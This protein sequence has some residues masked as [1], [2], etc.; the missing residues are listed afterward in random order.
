MDVQVAVLYGFPSCQSQ[1]R[2]R[3][4]ALLQ[5]AIDRLRCNHLPF[6]IAGDLNHHPSQLDAFEALT[7]QGCVT[8]EDCHQQL[9]GHALPPTFTNTTRNDVAILSSELAPMVQSVQVNQD[10]LVAGHNPLLFDL[11]CPD[12][13]PTRTMWPLPHPWIEL[14][15]DPAEVRRSFTWNNRNFEEGRELLQWSQAV[16]QAVDAALKTKAH[17]SFPSQGLPDAYR[18]RCEN[19]MP[20]QTPLTSLIPPGRHDDFHP[21]IDQPTHLLKAWTSQVRRLKSLY[22]RSTCKTKPQSAHQLQTEW[23]TVLRAKGCRQHF[24]DWI[25]SMPE[26]YP[27]PLS[28]PSAS[29]LY[30]MCQLMEHHVNHLAYLHNKRRQALA[31]FLKERDVKRTA[32]KYAMLG[33]RR[34]AQPFLTCMVLTTALQDP[35][36]YTILQALLH[37]RDYAIHLPEQE[38]LQFFEQVS[39][40]HKLPQAIMGPAGALQ[41]YLAKLDWQMTSSGLIHV[42][43][44]FDLHLLQSNWHDIVEAVEISWLEHV[45]VQVSSRH[46]CSHMPVINRRSTVGVFESLPSP[47]KHAI[48]LQLTG[49]PMTGEQKSK[50][51]DGSDLCPYCLAPDSKEHQ[52]LYCEATQTIRDQHAETCDMLDQH[53]DI[54]VVQPAVFRHPD[55]DYIRTMQFS[56]PEADI[57]MRG[58]IGGIFTDGT[59]QRPASIATRWAAYAVVVPVSAQAD[60]VADAG[61]PLE[62]MLQKHFSVA[63]LALVPGAQNIPRAELLAALQAHESQLEDAEFPVY[64]DSSYVLKSLALVQQTRVV[65]RLHKHRNFDLLRRWRHLVWGRGRRTPTIKVK[66]HQPIP[67]S[68]PHETW[69]RIGNAV[70]DLVAKRAAF[71]LLPAYTATLRAMGEEEDIMTRFFRAQL[72][73]R[74]ELALFRKQLDQQS[75]NREQF[76]PEATLQRYQTW[77]VDDGYSPT[78]SDDDMWVLDLSR[79]GTCF[80]HVL[81]QWLSGLRFSK[82]QDPDDCG[83]TWFELLC[84]FWLQTQM[85]VPLKIDGYYQTFAEM[86]TWSREQFTINDAIVSFAGAIKHLEFLLQRDILP[87]VRGQQIPSL[88]RLG[89]GCHKLGLTQRPV[90]PLQ[91]ESMQWVWD[92]L[93]LQLPQGKVT[94]DFLPQIRERPARIFSAY[95]PPA[96]D[97]HA[98]RE[99]RFRSRGTK[100]QRIAKS[101]SALL[102]TV[103]VDS[104][105]PVRGAFLPMIP[106]RQRRAM[107]A[108]SKAEEMMMGAGR[109]AK[110]AVKDT[111]PPEPVRCEAFGRSLPRAAKGGDGGGC[112]GLP[113]GAA[114]VD[115]ADE[116]ERVLTRG[117]V[118]RSESWQ[119]PV[120]AAL[121]AVA[122]SIDLAHGDV[123]R[124]MAGKPNF[125]PSSY[126]QLVNQMVNLLA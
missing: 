86:I 38:A 16:E 59:C 2:I 100:Q 20:R 82:A 45:S 61:M 124:L 104:K 46:G 63:G 33:D 80:T 7:H 14:D 50:F 3:T 94:F 43:A 64:T 84:N 96:G 28:C 88:Y 122:R 97:N 116:L 10:H 35:E 76:N 90:M 60:I 103:A 120:G 40:S 25:F 37:A 69:T 109:V 108:I 41:Y 78:F 71:Q 57:Q 44:F 99:A 68:T 62:L 87:T 72:T 125:H 23:N 73:M 123:V 56:L 17:P 9:Y 105:S 51:S 15:P 53:D 24:W 98:A 27:V 126:L 36:Q 21:A 12:T 70:A 54:Y 47:G 67:G 93:K 101:R 48:A 18:G 114:R 102:D 30:D 13:M 111:V 31:T 26:L 75:D 91:Q 121:P 65:V 39:Q 66:A 4:N 55:A 8:I 118:G 11:L 5:Y 42:A 29:L 115:E 32:I 34:N 110:G 22:R 113:G 89:G 106:G 117:P 52:V 1:S 77:A 81:I 19:R 107:V 92:F 74:Q 112:R 85:D 83:I 58:I 119:G 49:A 79:W 95:S 6:I